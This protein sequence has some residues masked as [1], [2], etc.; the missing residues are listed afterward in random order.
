LSDEEGGEEE[1]GDEEGDEEVEENI[2]ELNGQ[3]F[4]LVPISEEEDAE[5]EEFEEAAEEGSISDLDLESV[6]KELEDEISED[7]KSDGDTVEEADDSSDDQ[8]EESDDSSDDK[9]DEDEEYEIDESLFSEEDEEDEDDDKEEV[10]EIS[11]SSN[12]GSGDNKFDAADG[13]DQEDPGKGDQTKQAAMESVAGELK[14]YKEAV[15]YLKDKL[16]EV[17]IL[18]AK[19]LFTN[20]LFKEYVLDN[21]DK[22]RIVETFDRAQTVREIKL[23]YATLSESFKNNSNI[24]SIKESIGGASKS[25]KSTK[26]SKGNK[27]IISEEQQVAERFKKLAGIV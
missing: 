22:L 8:V 9:I 16:H 1:F 27:K 11:T 25:V 4:R 3:S 20:K 6:I 23:V 10:D 21:G 15:K 17:N 5:E 12:I 26:P 13:S 7:E 19:L 2:I 18:N 24:T 14:E